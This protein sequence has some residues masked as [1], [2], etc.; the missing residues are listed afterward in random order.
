MGWARGG[1]P[2][3]AEHSPDEGAEGPGKAGRVPTGQIL[4]PAPEA[5]KMQSKPVPTRA[6]GPLCGGVARK[7]KLSGG[8]SLAMA[9]HERLSSRVGDHSWHVSTRR[10]SSLNDAT[11]RGRQTIAK[12]MLSGVDDGE[13]QDVSKTMPRG[14]WQRYAAK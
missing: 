7:T 13:A 9:K 12:K 10:Q 5:P 4:D 11:T 14:L 3:D 6:R 2:D 8:R 1:R